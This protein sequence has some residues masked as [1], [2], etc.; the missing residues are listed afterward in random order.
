MTTFTVAP[1]ESFMIICIVWLPAG[2]ASVYVTVLDPV[3]SKEKVKGVPP[4]VKL[5]N[6]TDPFTGAPVIAE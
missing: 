4:V 3:V 5:V 2:A 6:T 1:V